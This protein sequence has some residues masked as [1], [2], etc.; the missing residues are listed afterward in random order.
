MDPLHI[1]DDVREKFRKAGSI[2]GKKS[3]ADR[4]AMLK[5]LEKARKAKRKKKS[6]DRR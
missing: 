4:E 6:I 2:G 1:P 3:A 5:R